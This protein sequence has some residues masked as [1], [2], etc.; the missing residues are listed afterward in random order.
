[1][2]DKKIKEIISAFFHNDVPDQIQETFEK[3]MLDPESFQEKND[4]LESLW[5]ETVD[6]PCSGEDLPVSPVDSVFGDAAASR[7]RDRRGRG[8][9]IALW[10]SSAAAVFFAVL[11]AVLYVSGRVPDVCLASSEGAKASFTL[12]DGT[13][14]WPNSGSTLSYSDGLGGGRR[15]V[16]LEGE[17]FFDVEKDPRRPFI[18]KTDALDITALG[19]E[20]TVSAYEGKDIGT[21]LQE[22]KVMVTGPRMEDGLVL[23]PDQAVIFDRTSNRYKVKK[24]KA[25]NHTAWISEKLDFYNMPLYDIVETLSHWYNADIR[26]SDPCLAKN[27]NL[28]LTVRQEPF[29]EIML[30]IAELVPYKLETHSENNDTNGTTYITLSKN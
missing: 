22:G 26:C 29:R 19:T 5:K 15:V 2:A 23:T 1:M 28:S 13:K 9:R 12:P 21:Y 11:S 20:F 4:A 24:V 10:L 7:S 30:A 6:C 16:N 18:V 3:W 17:A 25:S 14:V 8:G 27:I